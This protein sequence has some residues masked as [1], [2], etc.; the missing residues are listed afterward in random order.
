MLTM[1]YNIHQEPTDPMSGGPMET[2]LQLMYDFVLG[3]KLG[4]SKT[5]CRWLHIVM[6]TRDNCREDWV[7]NALQRATFNAKD[8]EGLINN[9]T[10]ILVRE[11]DTPCTQVLIAD[12]TQLRMSAMSPSWRLQD[13]IEM[14]LVAVG[15]DQ[16][17]AIQRMLSKIEQAN[18]EGVPIALHIIHD[19]P[20]DRS[21]LDICRTEVT[22]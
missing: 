16:S 14:L 19:G 2:Q 20:E 5:K 18:S 13:H 10:Q 12:N 21:N 17:S 22:L 4:Q 15:I 3:S 6:F 1:H 7:V 9:P 8:E 11:Y